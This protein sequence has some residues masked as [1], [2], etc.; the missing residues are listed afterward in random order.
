MYVQTIKFKNVTN[1]VI[2]GLQ[3]VNAMGF[4]I[5]IG[6]SHN[7]VVRN[8]NIT[9][10]HDVL[11]SDGVHVERSEAVNILDNIITTGEDCVSIGDG[12]LNVTVTGIT[13]TFGHGIR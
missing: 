5:F 3:S 2:E 4:H 12:S 7:V 6:D 10:P 11:N 1:G 13:C 8:V 9:S